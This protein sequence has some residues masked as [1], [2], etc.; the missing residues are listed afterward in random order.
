MA[1]VKC[2]RVFLAF[3][4]IFSSCI[5][6]ASSL[7]EW[8][9]FHL[10]MSPGIIYMNQQ[11]GLNFGV[12]ATATSVMSSMGHRRQVPTMVQ[13][14]AAKHN[15]SCSDDSYSES[16]KMKFTNNVFSKT[17]ANDSHTNISV[18]WTGKDD[19]TLIVVTTDKGS[20]PSTL[21]IS[22]NSGKDFKNYTKELNELTINHIQ[23]SQID[24]KLV[25]LISYESSASQSRSSAFLISNGSLIE[26]VLLPFKLFGEIR[27]HPTQPLKLLALSSDQNRWAWLSNDGGHTWKQVLSFVND[28]QWSQHVNDSSDTV[29]LS[30]G[31][32]LKLDDVKNKAF[33]LV[34]ITSDGNLTAVAER[35]STFEIT[36]KFI[37]ALVYADQTRKKCILRVSTDGGHRWNEAQLPVMVEDQFYK[38]LDM[39]DGMVS[40]HV[41]QTKEHGHGTLFTSDSNG[42]VFSESLRMH[43]FTRDTDH[44]DFYKVKSIRGVY[45]TS[46]LTDD[47]RKRSVIT[48]NRGAKW[49]YLRTPSNVNCQPLNSSNCHF[50]IFNRIDADFVQKPLSTK[51]ATGI[52]LTLGYLGYSVPSG[53][54]DVFVSSDGGYNWLQALNGPHIYA[55][56]DHGGLLVA[57]SVANPN[58]ASD[59]LKFSLDEGQ[60]WYC[61]KFTNETLKVTGLFTD[62]ESWSLKVGI[63]GFGVN[64]SVWRVTVI[65]FLPIIERKC[66]E[67]DDFTDFIPHNEIVSTTTNK[68]QQGC[69]LGLSET[70]R[71]LK[72]GIKCYLG[73][74]HKP[75]KST[76][77]CSCTED[78]YECDYGFY[79]P[80]NDQK[81]VET[82]S[83]KGEEL[84]ICLDGEE[85][86][87]VTSGYRKIPGDVCE[88]GFDPGD[89]YEKSI[90]LKCREGDKMLLGS[91]RGG[92]S[93]ST[94][95]LVI[96]IL[97]IMVMTGLIFG[98][99]VFFIRKFNQV[100]TSPISYRYTQL[101]QDDI[102]D[103]S[104]LSVNITPV[105]AANGEN[106]SED[107]VQ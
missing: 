83:F 96:L 78:D 20:R 63:W 67:P 72:K 92:P 66:S 107:E 73:Q 56:A 32:E 101:S 24:R 57:I 22:E 103:E 43:S 60:T 84:D 59:T 89:R 5:W 16:L 27:F 34:K 95:G 48:F 104:V 49:K 42:I 2:L 74:D 53:G 88:N 6:R 28:I 75:Q 19:S 93:S 61:Y 37:Y 15:D 64:D 106:S 94:T 105:T 33:D 55:I 97:L 14:T 3:Y 39:S 79:R 17:F 70:F 80:N 26:S 1:K 21:Y 8:K 40:I 4:C 35:V 38:I 9:K 99:S 86:K 68:Q 44:N 52:I 46:H 47:H 62:P 58:H 51:S 41:D 54:P 98:M 30:T 11:G 65:D 7:T 50:Q 12:A 71:K 69:L 100:N 81:C 25:I 10:K 31:K 13:P 45:I 29:Y 82:P 87:I 91:L 18:V 102:P 36:G 23:Q 85:K 77:R 90:K 76:E